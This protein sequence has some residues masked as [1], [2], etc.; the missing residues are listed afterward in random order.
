MPDGPT[1]GDPRA[2][3]PRPEPHLIERSRFGGTERRRPTWD[4]EGPAPVSRSDLS[5]GPTELFEHRDPRIKWRVFVIASVVILAF[6]VWAMLMPDTARSV[7]QSTVAWIATNL[8]WYYV[9][10]VTLVIVFVLWVALSKEGG[11]RLG[12]DHSRPQ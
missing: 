8:G 7:M 4:A 6:S 10:T 9:L 12:P 3:E 11:V 5:K 2:D 1:A